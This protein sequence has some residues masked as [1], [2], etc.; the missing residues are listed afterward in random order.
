MVISATSNPKQYKRTKRRVNTLHKKHTRNHTKIQKNKFIK[1]N[2]YMM[3]GGKIVY[4]SAGVSGC[5]LYDD[6]N[7]KQIIKYTSYNDHLQEYDINKKLVEL[8]KG[9][10]FLHN[11][12]CIPLEVST[13]D[14]NSITEEFKIC[15]NTPFALLNSENDTQYIKIVMENCGISL[16]EYILNYIGLEHV[17]KCIKSASDISISSTNSSYTN[18]SSKSSLNSNIPSNTIQNSSRTNLQSIDL[19]N[20]LKQLFNS[21]IHCLRILHKLDIIHSDLHLGNILYLEKEEKSQSKKNSKQ[22]FES[23]LNIKLIDFDNYTDPKYITPFK[24]FEDYKKFMFALYILLTDNEF[25]SYI[26]TV[27]VKGNSE[28]ELKLKSLLEL[29][30]K[31]S[32]L[33]EGNDIKKFIKTIENSTALTI[34]NETSLTTYIDYYK[35]IEDNFSKTTQKQTMLQCISSYIRSYI[36]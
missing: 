2:E 18:S 34:D 3:N 14:K 17:E 23:F 35:M 27:I 10:E 28:L 33:K 7:P 9:K 24:K 15:K 29:L 36:P 25:E 26:Q 22:E 8:A 31:L 4:K 5:I 19:Y 16:L 12:F 1:Q 11:F 13:V 21:V 30:N 20:F 32:T 6:A